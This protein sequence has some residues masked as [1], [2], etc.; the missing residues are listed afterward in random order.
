MNGQ[1]ASPPADDR[2]DDGQLTWSDLTSSLGRDLAPGASFT[3]VIT[4]TAGA[5]T[6]Y[7]P[8]QRAVN[9]AFVSSAY[10]D[11]DGPGPLP[12]AQLL[13]VQT[14]R[15]SVQIFC[16]CDAA[17]LGDY[18][19]R[20]VDGDG[21]HRGLE[22]LYD[23]AGIDN[24]KLHLYR[25]DGDGVFEPDGGDVLHGSATTGDNP[26]TPVLER[27][28]YQFTAA[29]GCDA[30]VVWWIAIDSANFL[31]GAPLERHVLT[32][33][34][35]YG[36]NP[37]LVIQSPQCA[38][39]ESID[40]GFWA[41]ATIGDRVW[42]DSDG[43]GLQD[44]NERGVDGV[45]VRLF[46]A[47]QSFPLRITSTLN[48][49]YYQFPDV[50]PGDYS[51][52]FLAPTGHRFTRRDAGDDNVDSD[53]N[54][55][56]G[57][58][59]VITVAAG[60]QARNWD[61]GMFIPVSLGDRV[62]WDS[63]GNGRQDAGE[64]GLPGVQ[65]SL[66]DSVSHL[67]ATTTTGVDG[68]YA[69]GD[70]VPGLYRVAIAPAEF[71][72]G[73]ML[74]GWK[75]SPMDAAG[76]DVDSDG[77]P[78]THYAVLAL[79]SGQADATV[80]FGFQPPVAYRFTA[81]LNTIEPVQVGQPLSF[82]L[83]IT[84][85]SSSWITTLPLT[86]LYDPAYL[87][88]GLGPGYASLESAD[89][90]DDGLLYWS[91]LTA[92]PPSGFGVD[93]APGASFAVTVTFRATQDTTWPGLPP[94]DRTQVQAIVS[95]GLADPD[96]PGPIAGLQPLATAETGARVMIT[97]P[98]GVSLARFEATVR[99]DVV[100][101]E[102]ETTCESAIL[103]FEVF[104]AVGDDPN[105]VAD[106][107]LQLLTPAPL[108]SVHAG[109]CAGEIYRFEDSGVGLDADKPA[110]DYRYYLD[111]LKLDGSR[112]R[113]RRVSSQQVEANPPR[114]PGGGGLVR[115]AHFRPVGA[116]HSLQSR[117]RSGVYLAMNPDVRALIAW[118][119]LAP[120]TPDDTPPI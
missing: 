63:D 32:S 8:Q 80:D 75:A 27:G 95:G 22:A 57:R 102:W 3:V 55:A 41:D 99:G 72:A 100:L 66:F 15:A 119:C 16:P 31:P 86:H 60:S 101:L 29:S 52:E 91:D 59:D 47:N 11:A 70:V 71:A 118:E 68:L 38:T 78:A 115:S 1:F 73:G 37:M 120:T 42:E 58:T 4:F 112:E 64:P 107:A 77:D 88:I 76:D 44:A 5:D 69:F 39:F 26:Y 114:S 84:N 14:A 103:G 48:D 49:G 19:W 12:P 74:H 82:T 56:T 106:D 6:T 20:D 7:L 25:D 116:R 94:D 108:L 21:D 33:A 28:W 24:V 13:P 98:T 54:P 113:R 2:F 97:A 23:A 104:R 45:T 36:P 61:A 65:L 18:V 10:A 51:L 96:G 46:A 93:L 109:S 90:L 117:D 35:T 34:H 50:S 43:D 9:T 105:Q 40:F 83:R 89:R 92:P 110:S 30:H 111:I 79:L 87:S 67:I 17:L 62:W 53:V 81:H 85:T